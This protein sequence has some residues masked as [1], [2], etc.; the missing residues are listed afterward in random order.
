MGNQSGMGKVIVA[1]LFAA[2]VAAAITVVVLL[3]GLPDENES[4]IHVDLTASW[5]G[6]SEDAKEHEGEVPARSR[7]TSRKGLQRKLKNDVKIQITTNQ[8][9]RGNN[10][11]ISSN[12]IKALAVA[13]AVSA[14]V[15]LVDTVVAA[16]VAKGAGS[17]VSVAADSAAVSKP[18]AWKNLDEEHHLGGRVTSEGYM[19]GKVVLVDRW[20]RNCPP[21]RALLPRMEAVWNSFKAKPFVLLGG[22]CKGWG[23]AD[24]VKALIEENKLTYPVYEDAGLAENE[25][26]YKGIPFLYVVD[27]TGKVRYKGH[28]ERLATE[29]LVTALTDM[30]LPKDVA[31]WQKYIDF[32]LKVLPGRA[33]VRLEEFRKKFPKEGK[34]YDA[35]YK[36]LKNDADVQKLAKLVKF[37][38]QAKDFDKTNKKTM[39][40]VTRAKIQSV[41]KSCGP[42]KESTNELV[43]QEAKNAIADLKWALT[44]FPG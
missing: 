11:N 27:E 15:A 4:R 37:A 17:P 26:E 6:N 20:G 40:Q 43:A 33:F 42:L 3:R 25:P 36:R 29:A 18:V 23:T 41:I 1:A 2:T 28:D 38:K 39:G 30:E 22:H 44:N 31:M 34:K 35:D 9:E 8:C 12:K 24:E 16:D 19:R 32:E 5:Q 14:G 10:M 7:S 21:C 13:S